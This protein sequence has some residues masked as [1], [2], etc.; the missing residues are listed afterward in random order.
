MKLTKKDLMEYFKNHDIS[1]Q[2][3]NEII[4]NVLDNL[5]LEA[6]EYIEEDIKEET[7]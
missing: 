6:I 5:V 4:T 7:K 3:L 2:K 1:K